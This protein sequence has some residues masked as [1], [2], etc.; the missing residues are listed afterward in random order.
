MTKTQ[1]PNARTDTKWSTQMEAKLMNIQ[2][3][4][5]HHQRVILYNLRR[6]TGVG[7][8]P[9]SSVHNRSSQLEKKTARERKTS[10]KYN[11]RLLSTVCKYNL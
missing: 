10:D 2:I 4:E 11:R 9:S 8:Q 1:S 3:S 7:I 6:S 5:T